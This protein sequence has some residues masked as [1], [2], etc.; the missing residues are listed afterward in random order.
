M[1]HYRQTTGCHHWLGIR[2]DHPADTLP[3]TRA[4]AYND[5]Y[6]VIPVYQNQ[7]Q[8]RPRFDAVFGKHGIRIL[9]GPNLMVLLVN[10][11]F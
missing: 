2:L 6:M 7:H 8:N 4:R 1:D 5:L 9:E 10:P 11:I 3:L